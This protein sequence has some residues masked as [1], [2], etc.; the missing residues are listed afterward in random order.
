MACHHWISVCADAPVAVLAR[1]AAAA[2]DDSRIRDIVEIPPNEALSIYRQGARLQCVCFISVWLQSTKTAQR[3]QPLKR[4]RALT[5]HPDA[6][7][8]QTQLNPRRR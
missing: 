6:A 5:R 7:Q 3:A 8:P 1:T 2:T 4:V